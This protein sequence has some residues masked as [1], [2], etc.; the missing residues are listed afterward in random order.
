M[1]CRAAI[2]PDASTQNSTRLPSRPSR[3][4][5]RRSLPAQL[6]PVHPTAGRPGT[7]PQRAASPSGGPTAA[8]PGAC[9]RRSAGRCCP[10][11]CCADRQTPDAWLRPGTRSGD[12]P[13]RRARQRRSTPLRR[14]PLTLLP[15]GCA[16]GASPAA[17][18]AVAPGPPPP[19]SSGSG[20]GSWPA[21]AP[22]RGPRRGAARRGR[23]PRTGYAG[24][25][26]AAPAAPPGGRRRW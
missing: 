21:R 13:E 8:G 6:E 24:D 25:G 2:E 12:R 18:A 5:S 10:R 7:G 22:A 1:R 26:A 19:S 3:T 4:A 9:A 15:L 11:R 17:S 16:V 23:A 14:P 20:S